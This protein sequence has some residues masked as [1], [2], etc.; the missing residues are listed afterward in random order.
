[1]T[2]QVQQALVLPRPAIGPDL[3]QSVEQ[4]LF[5]EAW[6]MDENRYD[7]WL[8]LWEPEMAYWVPI[9]ADDNDPL[10]MVS[11]IHDNRTQVEQRLIRLRGRLAY[12]QQ[13]KSRMHRVLGNVVVISDDEHST[14]VTSTFTL[15]EF[16]IGRQ[17]VYIGRNVHVLKKRAGQFSM[18]EK[19]VML[20]NSEDALGNLTFLL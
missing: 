12:A 5:Y 19:K 4:F 18:S 13:P 8:A 1:M 6:C 16:R 2:Y 7:E 3:Q 10:R 9:G 15:G 14:M 11:I 20:L 17:E